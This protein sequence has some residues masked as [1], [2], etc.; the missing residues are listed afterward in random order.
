MSQIAVLH[1]PNLNLL[2]TRQPEIYGYMTLEKINQALLDAAGDAHEMRAFQSNHEGALIDFIHEARSWA[3]GI[4]INPG[5]F[6]HY[7]YALRDAITT[8]QLPTVEVHLS[9]IH[10]REA[11][12]HTS[13]IAPVAVGQI[14]GFGWRSYLL[15]LQALLDF[16]ED[17]GN[18]GRTT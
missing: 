4:L 10:A 12:R 11:F 18:G 3:N 6:T 9:N 5:A 13:V 7:S 2:G 16:L 1:G 14:A 15:G 17:V 8:V